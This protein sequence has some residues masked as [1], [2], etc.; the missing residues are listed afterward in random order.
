MA[1]GPDRFSYDRGVIYRRVGRLYFFVQ[2]KRTYLHA[3]F[4]ALTF[5]VMNAQLFNIG[6]IPWLMIAATVVL[7][8]RFRGLIRVSCVIKDARRLH[9]K[10]EAPLKT[11]K[12]G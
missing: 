7:Y 3:C 12:R 1:V 10:P 5:P 6:I 4:F 2:W 9:R 11:G 8:I